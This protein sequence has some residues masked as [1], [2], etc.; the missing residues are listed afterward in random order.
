MCMPVYSYTLSTC[1]RDGTGQKTQD[2]VRF[3]VSGENLGLFWVG[4][5]QSGACRK[6]T[7]TA[8]QFLSLCSGVGKVL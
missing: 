1:V 7:P 6:F 8:E 5:M 4:S 3:R 2:W